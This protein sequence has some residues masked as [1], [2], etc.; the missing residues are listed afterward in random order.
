M[1]WFKRL[2]V[3][4]LIILLS[5]LVIGG[6]VARAEASVSYMKYD[7][8]L[9]PG[10][11]LYDSEVQCLSTAI[12]REATGL[13]VESKARVS[14]SVLNRANSSSGGSTLCST[15]YKKRK[16]K[17]GSI[18]CDYSWACGK[19]KSNKQKISFTDRQKALTIAKDTLKGKY[20]ALTKATHFVHCS[21]V[22]DNSGW[23]KNM[24]YLGRDTDKRGKSAHCFYMN[25]GK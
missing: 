23:L 10:H 24:K 15:V 14:Q 8:P 19:D 18:V 6:L 12:L 5:F 1:M 17:S 13:S 25:K 4:V 9:S 21:V 11:K 7:I 20:S 16:L 2:E 3:K 22:K